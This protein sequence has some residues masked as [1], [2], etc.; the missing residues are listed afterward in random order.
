MYLP[1]RI[2]WSCGSGIMRK[3]ISTQRFLA[4]NYTFMEPNLFSIGG[5]HRLIKAPSIKLP[6]RSPPSSPPSH[7]RTNNSQPS[8]HSKASP[9]H[10]IAKPLINSGVCCVCAWTT[11]TV[12]IW[13]QK[14]HSSRSILGHCFCGYSEDLL[15]M[16]SWN[17]K[18]K[19]MRAPHPSTGKNMRTW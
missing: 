12:V 13:S 16:P 17:Q 14:Q 2:Q 10:G 4:T 8:A 18:I 19:R 6:Q 5:L 9:A 1:K 15:P 7:P 11:A 3:T